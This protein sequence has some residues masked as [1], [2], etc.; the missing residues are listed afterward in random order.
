MKSASIE[1][2][3]SPIVFNAANDIIETNRIHF[4]SVFETIN[5][6]SMHFPCA[7]FLVVFL[8]PWPFTSSTSSYLVYMCAYECKVNSRLL[9]P[10]RHEVMVAEMK[11]RGNACLKK[12]DF[13]GAV[14]AYTTALGQGLWIEQ[15]LE[16][17]E[18]RSGSLQ[19]HV[20][21]PA[22][23]VGSVVQKGEK[24]GTGV[25]NGSS[26]QN[27]GP[28][29]SGSDD[30]DEEDEDDED[31]EKEEDENN[32]NN[33]GAVEVPPNISGR[34]GSTQEAFEA[35]TAKNLSEGECEGKAQKA[36]NNA[37]KAAASL[38]D[39]RAATA[40]ANSTS[41]EISPAAQAA[42]ERDLLVSHAKTAAAL[43]AN[44]SLA[45]LKLGRAADALR[46][47]RLAKG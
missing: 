25:E 43:L 23:S 12:K 36:G 8:I 46:D 20:S 44:R 29:D 22:T 3:K 2:R 6:S 7:S 47:A 26:G 30:D 10:V 4:F 11:T 34:F 41:S 15:A 37:G 16:L 14:A 40:A 18:A 35:L 19:E 45:N 1:K 27:D 9:A 38:S 28:G 5:Y 17:V 33:D 21:A 31:E 32:E 13:S 24:Q 42:A 39:R